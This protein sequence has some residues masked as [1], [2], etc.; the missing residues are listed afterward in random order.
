LPKA[1]GMITVT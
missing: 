1:R